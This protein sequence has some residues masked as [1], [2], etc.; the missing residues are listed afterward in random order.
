M[1][2]LSPVASRTMTLLASVFLGFDGA[3][4]TVFGVWAR[5]PVVAVMG[6]C[7]FFSSGLVWVYWRW[8]QRQTQ[9]LAAARR[10]LRQQEQL[11]RELLR[12]G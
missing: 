10:A 8:H 3:A 4:V 2:P 1:Y 7:L 6:V 9:E 12:D 11:L 5:H